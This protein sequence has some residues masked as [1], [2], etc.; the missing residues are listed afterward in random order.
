MDCFNFCFEEGRELETMVIR[1]ADGRVG[2][3]GW[4]E[5]W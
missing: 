1:L 5:Q 3:R 4:W 2:W